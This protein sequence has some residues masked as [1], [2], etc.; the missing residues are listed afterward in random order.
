VL[1]TQ[2]AA[3]SLTTGDLA[4]SLAGFL[5]FYTFLLVIEL[6]LMFKFGRLGPSSLHTGRYYFERLG[7]PTHP[8]GGPG[9]ATLATAPQRPRD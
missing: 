8:Q 9:T 1:P 6:Y 2:M 7:A 5:S 4:L 3:S